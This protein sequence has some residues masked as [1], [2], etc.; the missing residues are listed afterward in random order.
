L[1]TLR[2]ALE[3]TGF[4]RL[5]GAVIDEVTPDFARSRLPFKPELQQPRGF[6][7]GG[8]ICAL[9]DSTAALAILSASASVPKMMATISLN[10]HFLKGVAEED[11]LAE[12]RITH[13][14]RSVVFVEAEAKTLSGTL[15]A[16]AQL[17]FR[18]VL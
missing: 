9:I 4:N 17:A 6:I 15:A 11:V 2:D 1:A 12:A 10:I 7:H 18:V 14:G 3:K 5:I 16:K 13:R 8:A